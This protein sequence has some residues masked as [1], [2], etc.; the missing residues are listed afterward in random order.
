LSSGERPRPL[1]A[2]VSDAEE[3]AGAEY[4]MVLL[5]AGLSH[6]YEFVVVHGDGAV[7][8]ARTKASAAAVQMV[9]IPGL[10]RRPTPAATVRLLRCL[11]ELQPALV[12]VNA[13]DQGGGI[14]AL[15][16]AWRLPSPILTTLHNVL[17]GRRGAKELVSRVML[18]QAD[19]VIAVSDRLGRYLSRVGAAHVVVKNGLLAPRLDPLA[20]RRL[21]LGDDDFVVGGIGRLDRQ[22]GWD[23]L[24]RAAA[25]VHEARPDM[26]FVV[27]GEGPERNALPRVP[28][29]RHVAF[30]GHIA[31]AASLLGAF[32]L[33]VMPSRY[34]GLGLVAIEAMLSGVPVIAADIEGLAE[35]VADCGRIIPPE[36]HEDLA[37]AVLELSER[38]EER[39]AL[40]ARAKE[41]AERLF[42]AE[43][44]LAETAEVYESLLSAGKR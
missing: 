40:A 43:R 7:D 20:R 2:F 16:L 37:A 23:I 25:R 42:T 29:C 6:R 24:C 3:F 32:D 21:E 28:S 17:P 4:Y 15:S 9:S 19:R 33:V 39:E 38:P 11:R 41:R 10:R 36:D 22:K 35:V 5:L 1:V 44:M 13:S 12:H 8:E 26:K 18:R 14:A 34:E 27:I 30:L 31:D